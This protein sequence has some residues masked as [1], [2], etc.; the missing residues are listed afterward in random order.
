MKRAACVLIINKDNPD[1]ILGVSRK[2]NDKD[3][4]LPGGK[5]EEGESSQDCA[6]RE[7]IEETNILVERS[8]LIYSNKD[9][10]GYICETFLATIYKGEIDNTKEAGVVKWVNWDILEAGSFG[11]YNK[12]VK[13]SYLK[14]KNARTN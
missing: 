13:E 14:F 7:C 5:A 12:Q 11:D 9:V 3:F 8:I 2:D 10:N 1:E 6:I 4:G